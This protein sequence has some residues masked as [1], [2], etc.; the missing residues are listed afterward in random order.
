MI[1]LK[2]LSE[3]IQQLLQR[4][5]TDEAV[6]SYQITIKFLYQ[7]DEE[8]LKLSE[9]DIYGFVA[10]IKELESIWLDKVALLVVYD[11]ALAVVER[12]NK[13]TGQKLIDFQI[14]LQNRLAALHTLTNSKLI[15]L[16]EQKKIRL[17][18]V[19]VD[20]FF[21]GLKH[22]VQALK[23]AEEFHR[24]QGIAQTQQQINQLSRDFWMQIGT[25]WLD[26]QKIV[27]Q[28]LLQT[29]TQRGEKEFTQAFA[30]TEQVITKFI[31]IQLFDT[32]YA[33][34]QYSIALPNRASNF[35]L[36]KLLDTLI[37]INQHNLSVDSQLLKSAYYW[38]HYRQLL[39]QIRM[40]VKI[41]LASEIPIL[42]IQILLSQGYRTLIQQILADAEIVL[43]KVPSR[44][45]FVGYGSLSR[46]DMALYSDLECGILVDKKTSELYAYLQDLITLFRFGMEAL[47]ESD[48]AHAG[49]HLDACPRI[50][51]VE[52]LESIGIETVEGYVKYVD[53]NFAED[54]TR[55]RPMFLYGDKELLKVCLPKLQQK[56]KNTVLRLLKETLKT[57]INAS[58]NKMDVKLTQIDIKK[59]LLQPLTLFCTQLSYFYQIP[60]PDSSHP[61]VLLQQLISSGVFD[62]KFAVACEEALAYCHRIRLKQQLSQGLSKE[63]ERDIISWNS[64]FA[65]IV[66]HAL[67]PC[68]L[69]LSWLTEEKP[70][71]I[72]TDIHPLYYPAVNGQRLA[73]MQEQKI[74]E[75]NLNAKLLT[76][77]PDKNFPLIKVST[78]S[79]ATGYLQKEIIQ[80]LLNGGWID[81]AGKFQLQLKEMSQTKGRHLVIRIDISNFSFYLKIFPEMPGMEYAAGSLAR[82]LIGRG[83]PLI[84]IARFEVNQ[85]IYPVLLSQ[86]IRGQSL[87]EILHQKNNLLA[88]DKRLFGEM[89][90]LTMMLNPED[91]KPDNFILTAE[92]LKKQQGI[93]M[94]LLCIDNDRSFYPAT[95]EEEDNF[96][97]LVK[98]VIYCFDEMKDSIHPAIREQILNMDAYQVLS[99]WLDDLVKKDQAIRQLFGE[100]ELKDFFKEQAISGLL[101]KVGVKANLPEASIL[102]IP[103]REKLVAELYMKFITIQSIFKEKADIAYIDLLKRLEPILGHYYGKLLHDYNTVIDRFHEGPGRMYSSDKKDR[104]KTQMT[105]PQTLKT[106]QGKPVSVNDLI[107]RKDYYIDQGKREL[108]QTHGKC[109]NIEKIVNSI[110]AGNTDILK[111]LDELHL[112]ELKETVINQLDFSTTKIK[113]EILLKSMEKI[114]FRCLRIM[115]C[116]ILTDNQLLVI[117]KHSTGLQKLFLSNVPIRG[118]ELVS[119]LNRY[120]PYLEVVHLDTLPNLILSAGKKPINLLRVT[121]L[122]IRN[123]QSFTELEIKAFQLKK[124]ELPNCE[125]LT[126]LI[127]V[128]PEL[129]YLNLTNCK[130]LCTEGLDECDFGK[131]E[132]TKIK[133]EGSRIDLTQINNKTKL[134][135]YG[136]DN[137]F[138]LLEW[139]F[140][141]YQISLNKVTELDLS[142]V[143][144]EDSSFYEHWEELMN[145]INKNASLIHL[146]LQSN[147]LSSQQINLLC[148]KL[149]KNQALLSLDLCGNNVSKEGAENIGSLI[150]NNKGLMQVAMRPF[151]PSPEIRAT[152]MGWGGCGKSA[153]AYS[154]LRD[155]LFLDYDPTVEDTFRNIVILNGLTYVLNIIDTA[156]V[157]DLGQLWSQQLR[158]SMVV[159]LCC[160]LLGNSNEFLRKS[161]D[162]VRKFIKP[163]VPIILG[164]ADLKRRWFLKD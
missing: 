135:T 127:A 102:A 60:M 114:R 101:K 132:S 26:Q 113:A 15:T 158:A 138:T 88:L 103:L 128:T 55:A 87:D 6:K 108:I 79:M 157:D 25:Y 153:L 1:M 129:I 32:A 74:W 76:S 12:Y 13:I 115:N 81:K 64:E 130:S 18:Q 140:L 91:G 143:Q 63:E 43:G 3:Q 9:A 20:K 94:G 16:T 142:R 164:A 163:N 30:E 155:E 161:N 149:K 144:I 110:I 45:C 107:E 62:A 126:K 50:Q 28:D 47:G 71:D 134:E 51:S 24:E 133:A 92:K 154:Y 151:Q 99:T 53:D 120:C 123:C 35:P 54:N 141:I 33:C 117:L 156:G 44:Y 73:V 90:L 58:W 109:S 162:I 124:L 29:A 27:L 89:A 70:R 80:Q 72:T 104:Y 159:I 68:Q 56:E 5:K 61:I 136:F 119:Q 65:A 17:E 40:E 39:K 137:K 82:L 49:F 118:K 97:I 48:V 4:R 11:Q 75:D 66:R 78:A 67:F 100:K 23:V 59:D 116:A 139:K 2:I 19:K 150:N 14:A 84:E 122:I 147:S 106:L 160:S 131:L 21:L 98:S 146:N 152:L 31:D 112:D 42:E 22:N 125:F 96:T 38:Q 83:M 77:T 93:I 34:L 10:L 95:I 8:Q 85:E 121:E 7:V 86:T 52:K 37:R 41:K 57:F 111:E 105:L 145:V 69:L 36:E 148:Q 46:E